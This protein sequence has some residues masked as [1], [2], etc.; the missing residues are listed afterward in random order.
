[1]HLTV[2]RIPVWSSEFAFLKPVLYTFLQ[3]WTLSNDCPPQDTWFIS[4]YV[5]TG[6]LHSF[7]SYMDKS[8][9]K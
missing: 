6:V 9:L 5:T 4:T 3:I 8:K 7:S 2:T 1:M